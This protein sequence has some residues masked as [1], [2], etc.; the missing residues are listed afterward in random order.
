MKRKQDI[1]KI[2]DLLIEDGEIWVTSMRLAEATGKTHYNVN[3]DIKE[4]LDYLSEVLKIEE[5]SN[6]I[7]SFGDRLKYKIKKEFMNGRLET[8]YV[9]NRELV[10]ELLMS[11]SRKIRFSI[12]EVFWKVSDK[13]K[14]K[15]YE[16][17][18][19]DELN[20]SI[21]SVFNVLKENADLSIKAYLNQDKYDID[22]I[23]HPAN[24]LLPLVAITLKPIKETI[25][26]M[27]DTMFD[28]WFGPA[29][30]ILHDLYE[31]LRH[32]P[33]DDVLKKIKED[34][35]RINK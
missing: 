6:G 28:D 11:Y 18:N 21:D 30:V 9:L 19:I 24:F 5:H 14:E 12:L 2:L 1:E 15:G 4:T 8:I 23:D 13:L 7:I 26:S 3:R 25:S 32:K 34:D 29:G 31:Y 27:K 17:K 22:K 16:H 10:T 35:I 20:D 33:N